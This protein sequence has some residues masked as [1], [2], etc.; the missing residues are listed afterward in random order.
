MVSVGVEVTTVEARVHVVLIQSLFLSK[1]D[2][3]VVCPEPL[4]IRHLCLPGQIYQ[5]HKSHQ[6][7][8]EISVRTDKISL[9]NALL[10]SF[11]PRD[12]CGTNLRLN[13]PPFLPATSIAG[14]EKV[15]RVDSNAMLGV[16]QRGKVVPG[17]NVKFREKTMRPKKH[18]WI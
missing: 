5:L 15:G 9:H 3:R 14:L 18:F 4:V 2:P 13:K 6:Q 10:D 11:Q 12:T 8:A 16:I 7:V 17:A 1:V